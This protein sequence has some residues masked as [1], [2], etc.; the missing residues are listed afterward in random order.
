MS[1][2]E[3]IL[4]VREQIEKAC[5]K[6]GR[7]PGEVTL[8]GV[9]KTK[10]AEMIDEAARAGLFHAGENY[11]TEFRDK[12]PLVHHRD[13][14]H[15]HFIGHLQTNKVKYVIDRAEYIHS[16]DSLR[17]LSEIDRLAEK[18]G[19]I[20][21]V[22]LEVNISGE[23][24]KNGLAP[25]EAAPLLEK[26]AELSHV[27]VEGL[28]TM[29]PFGAP[30]GEIRRIF[31]NL[32][33]LSIDLKPFCCNNIGMSVLSMGMSNDFELAILEGANFVRVGSAIYGKR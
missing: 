33:Q 5:Q 23:A 21:K 8:I 24:S 13:E 19:K 14:I 12:T 26:T 17:L 10:P 20:Q 11:A 31:Q 2:A 16:V 29:A 1:I 22:L 7:S 4:R 15:W 3:N 9:S 6:A 18:R 27:R 25:G 30:E 32:R 28:M